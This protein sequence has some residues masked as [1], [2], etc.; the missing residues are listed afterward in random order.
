MAITLAGE[1]YKIN[2]RTSS[3]LCGEGNVRI[4]FC[5]SLKDY[6]ELLNFCSVQLKLFVVF[7]YVNESNNTGIEVLLRCNKRVIISD[8]LLQSND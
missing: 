3:K 1:L 8:E 7:H 2:F 4:A 5:N 6:I